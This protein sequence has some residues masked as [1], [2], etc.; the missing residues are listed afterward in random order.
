MATP[1]SPVIITRGE[2]LEMENLDK[3]KKKKDDL[4]G[5]K[6]DKN[7]ESTSKYCCIDL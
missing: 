4:G 6:E 3:R 5:N 7:T 1:G 2:R